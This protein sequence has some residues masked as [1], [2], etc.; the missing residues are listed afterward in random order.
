MNRLSYCRR[1]GARARA[2]LVAGGIAGS[3]AA[4]SLAPAYHRPA[5][6]PT[7][8]AYREASGW[9]L[10]TPADTEPRGP[11]WSVFHDTTL[12]SLES[13]VTD[14]NQDLKAA[15]ARL[16]RREHRAGSRKQV[17]FLSSRRTAVPLAPTRH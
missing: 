7:P 17:S 10:A 15:F 3:V 12:N 9:K 16:S 6:A 5:T 2:A 14:A 11:W 8:V 13:K 1:V 4:C